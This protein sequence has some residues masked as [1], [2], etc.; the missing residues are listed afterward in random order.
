VAVLGDSDS[1]SYHDS[2][3]FADPALRGGP[4]RG[5]TFQWTEIWARLRPTEVDL[6]P[7]GRWGTRGTVA[8]V[9]RVL[10]LEGRAPPKWDFRYNYAFSGARCNTLTETLAR[11]APPLVR[12][13]NREPDRWSRGVVVVRIG[14][15]SIGKLED[16]DEYARTGPT[17]AIRARVAECL[18]YIERAVVLIR[19]RHP[20]TRVVLV[21][22]AD[23]ANWAK[24]LDRWQ[25]PVA[26]ANIA[27][28]LD[29]FD[30]R[31]RALAAADPR[32]AFLDERAWFARHWGGRDST[33]RPAYHAVGVGGAVP[34]SN[35]VGDHPRNLAVADGH[36]GTVANGL[37]LQE[38]I[39]VIESNWRL[40]LTSVSLAEI[41]RLADPTG[42][43][44][45]RGPAAG[46][47]DP[48]RP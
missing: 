14:I 11:Q 30:G 44:G 42:S 19:T 1:H 39:R 18:G 36:A 15:N 40:G 3:A 27:G 37:W 34:V 43:L 16:L 6:G 46:P 25:H 24:A 38:L 26:L 8:A 23:D 12:R 17:P 22:I 13:M 5:T 32:T 20:A 47:G 10:G 31:L 9:W 4:F 7:W 41:A 21:G 29:L 35:T 33:G 48:P 28:V 45:I 2:L